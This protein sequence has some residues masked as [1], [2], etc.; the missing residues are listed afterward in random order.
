M[1]NPESPKPPDQYKW[2]VKLLSVMS[3]V[4]VAA[5]ILVYRCFPAEAALDATISTLMSG[6]TGALLTKLKE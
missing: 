3:L 1:T 5:T 4:L 6:F 2:E